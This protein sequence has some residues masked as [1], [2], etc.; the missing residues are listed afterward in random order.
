MRRW[1]HPTSRI[2]GWR[3]ILRP[4]NFVDVAQAAIE[5][6]LSSKSPTRCETSQATTQITSCSGLRLTSDQLSSRSSFKAR[7]SRASRASRIFRAPGSSFR[8]SRLSASS[9]KVPEFPE[10][11]GQEGL[12]GPP[13]PRPWVGTA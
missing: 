5:T 11:P 13:S 8:A 9:S 4:A 1:R 3:H 2:C 6:G 7:R 12:Q 10:P